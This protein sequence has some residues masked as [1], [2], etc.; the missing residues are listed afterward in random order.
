[1][2][3]HLFSYAHAYEVSEGLVHYEIE[4]RPGANCTEPGYFNATIPVDEVLRY[5]EETQVIDKVKDGLVVTT[6]ESP[7]F[8]DPERE[9]LMHTDQAEWLWSCI[10]EQTGILDDT[11]FLECFFGD[12]L[13]NFK[14]SQKAEIEAQIKDVQKAVKSLIEELDAAQDAL[15]NLESEVRKYS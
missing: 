6:V 4:T 10:T 7:T 5:L 8:D 11:T 2:L 14:A 3:Q 9:L 12:Q 1:M 15:K 13:Q